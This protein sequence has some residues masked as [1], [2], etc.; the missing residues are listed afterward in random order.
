MMDTYSMHAHQTVTGII[1]GKPVELGGSAGRRE[2]TGRGL[3]LVIR[4]A[5]ARFGLRCS[6]TSV[7]IQGFGN[8][9]SVTA[10]LLAAEG[11]KI[12]AVSNVDGGIHCPKGL[13]LGRL[14][15]Y[16]RRNH[17]LQG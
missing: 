10:Q 16:H 5:C 15:D 9:G 2:A 7:V 17:T 3:M 14:L 12:V 6:D 8:V 11:F 13:D 1:T 4:E